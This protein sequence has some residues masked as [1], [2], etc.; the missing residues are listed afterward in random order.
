[1]DLEIDIDMDIEIEID[2]DIDISTFKSITIRQK[3]N[4]YHQTHINSKPNR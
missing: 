2:M 4:I 3:Y 1:M